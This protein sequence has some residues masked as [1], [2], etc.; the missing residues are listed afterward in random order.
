M[1]RNARAPQHSHATIDHLSPAH[2]DSAWL[3]D[4]STS[5]STARARQARDELLWRTMMRAI[6][7]KR[8]PFHR[9]TPQELAQFL[10]RQYAGCKAPLLAEQVLQMIDEGRGELVTSRSAL[11]F[12]VDHGPRVGVELRYLYVMPGQRK[13]GAGRA[14]IARLRARYAHFSFFC[15]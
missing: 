6:A 2:A 12:V 11:A 3:R 7:G 10:E 15:S 4:D 13:R 5:T 1:H 8:V 9:R 14:L